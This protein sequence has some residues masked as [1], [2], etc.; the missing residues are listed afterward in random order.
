MEAVSKSAILR[1]VG[2]RHFAKQSLSAVLVGLIILG[3]PTYQRNA[4]GKQEETLSNRILTGN[5]NVLR[6]NHTATLLPNGKVLVAAGHSTNGSNLKSAELYDPGTDSWTVTGDLNEARSFHTGT[7]LP[8]GKLLIA[9]GF[10]TFGHVSSTAELYDPET[11]VWSVTGSL[12]SPRVYHTATLL[13]DGKVLVVGG[14]ISNSWVFSNSAEVY[15]P[16]SGKWTMTASLNKVRVSH[17]ATLLHDGKVLVVGGMDDY[18]FPTDNIAFNNAELYD[19]TT[20]TWRLT[21]DLYAGRCYH[22]A[23][24]LPNGNVLILG[25]TDLYDYPVLAELYDPISGDWSLVGSINH[26]RA[27]CSATLLPSGKVLITG[28]N[29]SYQGSSL[30]SVEVYD[31]DTGI[32]YD[33][34]NLTTPR[35]DHTATLLQDGRV[36]VVGGTNN[37]ISGAEIY[38]TNAAA[39]VPTI[40]SA[41]V[42]GKS[43]L[44]L[45][46]NFSAGAV[47]LLNGERQATRNDDVNPATSLIAKRAGKRIQPG[48]KIQVRNSNGSMSQ[49]I[50]F[51][52]Q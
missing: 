15:D 16:T 32:S 17:T 7:L 1:R 14:I 26:S 38:N 10:D 9:G 2:A 52:G 45:G 4:L 22:T 39:P 44:V 21:G 31:P 5:I 43:L 20:E 23:T 24:L 6:Y 46:E 27:F 50:S 51:T 12:N 33:T 41:F 37:A 36:L 48:D 49:E 28:G 29:L 34:A 30:N 13:Q 8:S 18:N 19:P 35:S 42:I 11:G 40:T 3:S 47:I 25:G